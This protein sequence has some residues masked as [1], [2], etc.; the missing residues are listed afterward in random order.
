V[1]TYAGHPVASAAA[2]T[3]LRII[4][5]EGLVENAA[6]RE[7]ELR[8]RLIEIGGESPWTTRTSVIGLLGS[9]EFVL[10]DDVDAE[11]FRAMLWHQSYEHGVVVRVTRAAQVV[12]VFFYPALVITEPQMNEA[13][14]KVAAAVRY[15]TAMTLTPEGARTPAKEPELAASV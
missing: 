1:N 15:V 4:D 5:D 7:S 13:L 3:T 8:R 14:D 11:H 10:P 12:S 6:V 2:L 9:L